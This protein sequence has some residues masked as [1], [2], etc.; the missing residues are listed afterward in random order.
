MLS[1]PLRPLD[2]SLVICRMES[3]LCILHVNWDLLTLR[4]FSFNTTRMSLLK[5]MNTRPVGSS[6]G[7]EAH[8]MMIWAFASMPERLHLIFFRLAPIHRD[9]RSVFRDYPGVTDD[10]EFFRHLWL[11]GVTDVTFRARKLVPW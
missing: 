4:S 1:K 8:V 3:Q 7:C 11:Y 9:Y 2:L 5:L 6:L 10:N